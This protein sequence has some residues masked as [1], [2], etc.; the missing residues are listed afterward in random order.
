MK[1]A[2]SAFTLFTLFIT[3]SAHAQQTRDGWVSRYWDGCKPSCSWINNAQSSSYGPTKNCDISNNEIAVTD[4][5]AGSRSSGGNNPTPKPVT[6]YRLTVNANPAANG[7]VSLSPS[8]TSFAA[9]TPVTVTAN[10]DSGYI[11][12]D[13][14]GAPQGSIVAEN[15]L[16]LTMPNSDLTITANFLPDDAN[17][18]RYGSVRHTRHSQVT[19]KAGI[20]GFTECCRPTTVIHHIS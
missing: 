1:K 6:L 7:S 4:T 18:V 5:G 19:L 11:L 3:A 13:W 17:S 10:P 12:A 9:G 16:I 20:K 8:D 15:N 14:T 2:L